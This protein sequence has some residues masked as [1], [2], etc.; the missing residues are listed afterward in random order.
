MATGEI[1]YAQTAEAAAVL[2]ENMEVGEDMLAEV[3]DRSQLRKLLE[4]VLDNTA[5]VHDDGPNANLFDT[6]KFDQCYRVARAMAE[7]SLLPDHL[8]SVGTKNNKEWLPKSTVVA[9]CF[10]VVNQAVRWGFDP[11]AIVDETYVVAGKLGYQGKL[12]AAVVNSRAG[13]IGRLNYTHS[14]TGDAMTVTVSG[15]FKDSPDQVCEITLSVKD[16]K[17]E[18]EMWK[19]DPEQKLCYSGA[20]KWARRYCPEVVLGVLTDDDVDK[21]VYGDPPAPT[22]EVKSVSDLTSV[23]KAKTEALKKPTTDGTMFDKGAPDAAEA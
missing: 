4:K 1:K 8:K 22:V 12:I 15:R 23:V 18:N 16:A 6:R 9:N 21:I 13:L 5:I 19:K 20:I 14:G 7:M 10:R 3:G 17:T 11:Y 2:V